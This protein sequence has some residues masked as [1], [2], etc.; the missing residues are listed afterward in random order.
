MNA[1]LAIAAICLLPS[2][3]TVQDRC[4]AIEINH[5]YDD[6]GRLLHTQVIFWDYD[7]QAPNQRVAAWR[8]VKNPACRPIRNQNTGEWELLWSDED[9]LRRV[10]ARSFRETWTQHDPEMTSR[11][12]F[13]KSQ[14]RGLTQRRPAPST[15][16]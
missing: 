10:T 2:D 9:G 5:C 14:R 8:L 3:E 16:P 7:E 15:L 13:P 12:E 4:D 11:D 6:E 1:I